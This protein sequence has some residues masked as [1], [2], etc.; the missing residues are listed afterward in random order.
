LVVGVVAACVLNSSYIMWLGLA[1][2]VSLSSVVSDLAESMFKRDAAVK[3][4][5][6]IMPSH[7]GILDRFDAFIISVPFAFVYLIIYALVS[8]A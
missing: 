6:N 8:V 7:G 2:V 5:G 1:L 3:D 4:S